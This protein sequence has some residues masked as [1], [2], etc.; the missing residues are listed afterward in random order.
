MSGFNWL[1]FSDLHLA[2]GG[3]FNTLYAR[4]QLFNF[5]RKETSANRLPCDYIFITGDIA[6]KGNY[7]GVLSN[8]QQLFVSL[9][10]NDYSRVFWAVGNHDISRDNKIRRL[11]IEDIRSK[12]EF[13]NMCFEDHMS[14]PE[15][16]DYLVKKA[17]NDY[18]HIHRIMLNR[19]AYNPD[20]LLSPHMKYSLPDL[21]LVVLNTCITSCDSNDE[22]NLYIQECGLHYVFEGLD[23]SKPTIVLGHHGY[24][25]FKNSEQT[26]LSHLFD[27][28]NVDLYLCGH[29][30]RLGYSEFPDASRDIHQ[31]SCGGNIEGNNTRVSFLHGT[32]DSENHN[33]CV[34]VFS[35][36][37]NGNREWQEDRNL[38]RR[39]NG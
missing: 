26:V 5:L 1:H 16:R 24:Q 30:H 31:I 29:V 15:I 6:H 21:N 7:D 33:I 20:D 12:D 38:N 18:H 17:S 9:N 11:L 4:T 28:R 19:E 35:Y 3:K 39:L 23:N 13:N 37:E 14:D 22:H 34:K 36:S 10:W 8:I 32:Y 2:P 25:F 27:S